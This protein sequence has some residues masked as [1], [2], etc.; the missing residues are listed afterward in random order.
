LKTAYKIWVH[1][2]SERGGRAKA[3]CL[4]NTRGRI[5]LIFQVQALKP[6]AF[7]MG[8]NRFQ[9]APPHLVG[10]VGDG[11]SQLP[12]PAVTLGVAAQVEIESKS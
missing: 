1:G 12:R 9:L 2:Q 7:N 4:L 3:W 10:D 8:F 5:S 6:G 11:G